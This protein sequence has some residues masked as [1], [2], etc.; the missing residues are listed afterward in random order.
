MKK[1]LIIFCICLSIIVGGCGSKESTDDNKKDTVSNAISATDARE[2]IED[3]AI[4]IDVRTLE[5]YRD[6]HIEGAVLL[7]IDDITST[8]ISKIA[9]DKET[10]LIVYCASGNRSARA[11]KILN[12]LG[13]N[14]VYDLGSINNW[15]E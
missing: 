1:Y 13:Y 4:L 2:K 11:V 10:V 7:T 6:Y 14:N 5:E 9:E 12:D 8:S 15:E 3:G